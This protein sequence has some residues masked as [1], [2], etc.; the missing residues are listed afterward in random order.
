L[1]ACDENRIQDYVLGNLPADEAARL[2]EHLL[3]CASCQREVE[4]YQLLFQ[5]LG[6]LPAPPTPTGIPEAVLARLGSQTWLARLR[7][8]MGIDAERPVAAALAGIV[9]GILIAIFRD[10]ILLALGQLAGG[11][12][13]DGSAELVRGLQ[14]AI[15]EITKWTVVLEV[16]LNAIAHLEPLAR[17]LGGVLTAAVRQPSGLTILLVLATMLLMGRLVGR[18]RREELSHANH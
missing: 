4:E 3:G 8:R 18:A 1:N 13:T 12:V 11:I 16:V 6:T 15:G 5:E 14:T 2:E 10:P 9:A 17:A 7:R